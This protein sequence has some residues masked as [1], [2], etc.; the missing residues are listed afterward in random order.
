VSPLPQ[1]ILYSRDE[2]LVDRLIR[3]AT[4]IAVIQP[5]EAQEDLEQWI[6]QFGDSVLLADLRAPHCLDIL[7]NIR[8][9]MP[10]T[11]VIVIGADRSD[12]MLAAEVL[13][14]YAMTSLDPDQ[15]EFKAL[16]K[17]AAECLALR[18]KTDVL[19]RELAVLNAQNTAPKPEPRTLF[20]A[21][22]QNFS[23]A[24]RNFDNIDMLF[25]SVVE[26]LVATARVTRAGIFIR[27]GS[28]QEYRYKAGTRCL[29]ATE[30]LTVQP[31]DPFVRWIELHT[32]LISRKT[33]LNI[34]DPEE[35]EMLKQMLDALG[36]EIIIPLYASGMIKGWI[37][38]GQRSTGIP[39]EVADLE[40]LTTLADHISTTLEKA[41]QYEATA[42]QKALAETL[43]HS[44][45]FGI[46]ACDENATVRWFNSTAREIMQPEQEAI[47]GSPVEILGS[48]VADMLRCALDKQETH[49]TREW[50]DPRI[51]RTLSAET[52]HL[53]DGETCVGAMMML[54]DVTGAK[55]LQEKEDQLERA[56]FWNELAS[57]MSHE[58]RNPLVAIKT[59]SQLLPERYEDPDFRAEFSEQVTTE[60]DQLNH[61]IDKINEF[62]NPPKPVFKPLDVRKPIEFAVTRIQS[63]FDHENLKIHLSAD[64]SNLQISGDSPSLEECVY[65][66]LR[67]AAEN[68]DNKPGARVNVTVKGRSAE[69]GNNGVYIM[70]ADNGSGIDPSLREKV[71]SPFSTIKARG[72]GLGLPIAKRAVIDHNG[73]IDIDTSSG[74][75]TVTIKLPTLEPE[76]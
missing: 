57:S 30:Q 55:L 67:N 15:R 19:E 49:H 66:L 46:I 31:N 56:A 40:D 3:T 43:L 37:F 29:A 13:E 62:A 51:R 23:K 9:E 47:I 73:Q 4:P 16:L 45:P 74:G 58:I 17:Q 64:E 5:I 7:S 32:H 44:I 25:D 2:Q 1:C 8:R 28:G 76:K 61:I 11:V 34:N 33:L 36:A 6:S 71:Y 68:L 35:R 41:L 65:H 54:H 21:P 27:A 48:H 14:P 42:L 20:S 12:P 53:M 63:E 10:A 26:G 70:I 22:L 75:T 38:I 59:F 60:V 52:R 39:F 18:K 69:H 72:L 50:S 24:Q